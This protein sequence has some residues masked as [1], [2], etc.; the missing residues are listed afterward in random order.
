[1]DHTV[2]TIYCCGTGEH[3]DKY[4]T[5]IVPFTW[6]GTAGSRVWINDGPGNGKHHIIKSE[7]VLKTVEKNKSFWWRKD[8]AFSN[9]NTSGLKGNLGGV[10]T[11]DNIINTL[12][13]LWMEYYRVDKPKFGTINLCGWSRGAVTCIMLAHAI[14]KAGFKT[15]IPT[16]RV[17]IF[18]IDPVPGGTNDFG[19]GDFDSTGRAGT[20]DTLADCINEYTAVLAENVGGA[21]GTVFRNCSPREKGTGANPP[22]KTEYPF[23]GSHSNVAKFNNVVGELSV[24]LCHKFLERHGTEI[25]TPMKLSEDDELE[26]YARILLHHGKLKTKGVFNK[27]TEF[28]KWEVSTWRA[29]IVNNSERAHKFFVNHHHA[30][31]FGQKLPRFAAYLAGTAPVTPAD[32]QMIAQR[33]PRTW[34]ALVQV[35]YFA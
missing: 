34:E 18:A 3:R 12:Q 21:M 31:L 23:P 8:K 7:H 10:G 33:Y 24:S 29:A 1:M 30:L 15:L 27:K 28:K 16:L 19:G 26:Q 17:N 11:A 25:L 9:Q 4:A 35:G 20:P 14:D 13:W 2:V 22:G 6:R 32:T 5:N